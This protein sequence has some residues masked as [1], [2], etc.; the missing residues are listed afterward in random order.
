MKG[1]SIFLPGPGERRSAHSRRRGLQT[2]SAPSGRRYNARPPLITDPQRWRRV[3]FDYP[4]RMVI[5]PMGQSGKSYRIT[6]DAD[7]HTLTL[8]KRDDATWQAT[9]A[10]EQPEEGLL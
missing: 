4:G 7:E 8:K 10:Y 5:E 2:L 6:L 3:V 1:A 9:L